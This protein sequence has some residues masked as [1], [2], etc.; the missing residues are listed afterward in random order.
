MTIQ[1]FLPPMI[2]CQMAKGYLNNRLANGHC[3]G[4]FKG[5]WKGYL[6]NG[7]VNGY[8]S[9]NDGLPASHLGQGRGRELHYLNGDQLDGH[10]LNDHSNGYSNGHSNG[11]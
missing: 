9:N 10:S 1:A 11:Y 5:H 2:I 3:N 6:A 7:H 4:N 8:Y